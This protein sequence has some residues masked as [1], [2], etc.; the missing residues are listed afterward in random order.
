M[1]RRRIRRPRRRT[2][3]PRKTTEKNWKGY[4]HTELCGVC[5]VGLIGGAQI[6]VGRVHVVPR[7]SGWDWV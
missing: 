3:R 5:G 4:I 2:R 7:R 1:A 6:F